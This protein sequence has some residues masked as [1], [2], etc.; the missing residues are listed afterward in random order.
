MIVAPQAEELP[1]PIHF[2]E[3]LHRLHLRGFQK[4]SAENAIVNGH[5]HDSKTTL[6]NSARNVNSVEIQIKIYSFNFFVN[7]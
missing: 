2:Q 4:R 7:L 3:M 5:C 1:K 6:A